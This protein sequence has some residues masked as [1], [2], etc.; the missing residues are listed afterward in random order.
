MQRNKI[1]NQ[2]AECQEELVQLSYQLLK[3]KAE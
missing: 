1:D 2:W 3:L